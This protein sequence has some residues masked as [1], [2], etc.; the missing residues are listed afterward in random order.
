M[1]IK[2]V[3][4]I[5]AK[6]DLL[7]KDMEGGLIATAVYNL[8]VENYPNGCHICEVEID[9]ETG[10]ADVVS[11]HVLDDFGRVI[12]PML[13][14]GQVH[15]GVAQGL[16][17]ALMEQVVYD[18]YSGQLLTGSFMDYA[19]PRADTVPFFTT[20]LSEVPSPTHPLGIRPA[21]EGGTTPALAVVIN[22]IV[23]ALAEFG[24][25]HIEMPA[26]PERVWRAI[27]AN[28]EIAL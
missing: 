13:V 8:E 11:Y 1:T 10:E 28:G 6:P 22:A 24:V 12:N 25:S 7:P 9:G 17:Q 27:R 15:G 3:A 26:T 2:E 14:E 20:E 5:A 18:R 16:G 19:M 23:D 21:G 4:K